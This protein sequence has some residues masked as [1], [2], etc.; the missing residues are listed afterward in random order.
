MQAPLNRPGSR[1]HEDSQARMYLNE[2]SVPGG[3]DPWHAMTT[4]EP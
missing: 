3:S 1:H 4:K 2:K